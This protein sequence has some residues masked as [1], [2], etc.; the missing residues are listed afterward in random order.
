MLYFTFG[1]TNEHDEQTLKK[2]GNGLAVIYTFI[3]LLGFAGAYL[4]NAIMLHFTSLLCTMGII[5]TGWAMFSSGFGTVQSEIPGSNFNTASIGLGYISPTTG[6]MWTGAVTVIFLFA[7]SVLH[8][9][10]GH[11]VANAEGGMCGKKAGG[12]ASYGG[13]TELTN[14]GAV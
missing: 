3:I 7:G 4:R 5:F 1:H 13:S 10:H 11:R 2:Q 14:T 6:I 9:V 12:G 8:G